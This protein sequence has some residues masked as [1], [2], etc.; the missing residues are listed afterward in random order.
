MDQTVLFMADIILTAALLCLLVLPAFGIGAGKDGRGVTDDMAI[1][2]LRAKVEGLSSLEVDMAAK[3]EKLKK[4]I[5][6]LDEALADVRLAGAAEPAPEPSE[7][8]T[9]PYARA[10]RLL[11]S[12]EPMEK[13]LKV[14][15]L[16]RGEA[17][18]LASMHAMTS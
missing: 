1:E 10:R 7:E 3:Q 5:E 17:E 16:T 11:R 14:C 6:R 13:V 8:D 4:I 2:A 12:G 15:G 9:G 18:V